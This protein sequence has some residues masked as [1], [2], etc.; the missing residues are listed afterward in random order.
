MLSLE[1]Q[2]QDVVLY[3]CY[4][5]YLGENWFVSSHCL[6]RGVLFIPKWGWVVQTPS[7][8]L[9]STSP[10]NVQYYAVLILYCYVSLIRSS[11]YCH[12]PNSESV[13]LLSVSLAYLELLATCWLLL[14]SVDLI[15]AIVCKACYV[16]F[17]TYSIHPFKGVL[18]AKFLSRIVPE[19]HTNQGIN[20][21]AFFFLFPFLS[22]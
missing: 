4:F 5:R 15:T 7:L 3:Y 10:E 18:G 1:T 16:K 2:G 20:L 8:Q 13:Q 6:L 9:D 21:P 22:F 11:S 19:F 12:P 14:L 17:T